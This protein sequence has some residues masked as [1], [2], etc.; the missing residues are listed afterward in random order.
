MPTIGHKKLNELTHADVR[1]VAIA[2][3]RAKPPQA[4]SSI[5]RCKAV[6]LKMLR[7]DKEDAPARS[8]PAPRAR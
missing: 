1:A 3:R 7:D 2:Q 8:E 5:T 6:L 4:A